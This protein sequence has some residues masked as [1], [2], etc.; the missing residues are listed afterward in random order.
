MNNDAELK[1]DDFVNS[2][3]QLE[4]KLLLDSECS[5]LKEGP[6]SKDE[7]IRIFQKYHE[8]THPFYVVKVNPEGYMVIY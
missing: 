6:Y 2:S 8:K 5:L 4:V 1:F 3:T 7:A